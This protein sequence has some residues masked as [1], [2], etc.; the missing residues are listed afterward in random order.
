MTH[1]RSRRLIAAIG[2]LAL[3]LSG[4]AAVAVEVPSAGAATTAGGFVG[5]TPKRLL[6]TRPDGS[7]VTQRTGCIAATDGGGAGRALTVTGTVNSQD[8]TVP[9]SASAVALNVTVVAPSAAGFLTVYPTGAAKPTASSVNYTAGQVVPNGVFVKV[10]AGGQINL[11]ANAGCPQ[12]IVDVV[13]YFEGTTPTLPGGFNGVTPK[14]LLDTRPD[15]TGVVQATGCVAA[16]DGGG[17]GRALK[18]TG[19]VNSQDT[20]VPDGAAAVALNVTV[21]NPSVAGFVTVYP[22]GAAKPNASSVNYTAGQVVPNNVQ[23]AV[24][25]GGQ[26]NLFA[27]GGCPQVIVDVVGYTTGGAPVDE[28]GFIGV[29]P[30]RLLDTRPDGSAVTQR[31]GCVAATDGFGT[32]RALKVTGTVNS[33]S[34]TVPDNASAVALNIT[35]VTPG[36]AGFLTAYP[37]GATK[38]NAS[39]LNFTAGQVVPNGTVVKVGTGGQI[40]LFANAGCPQVIVDVVGYYVGATAPTGAPTN[41]DS[42]GS[43]IFGQLGDPTIPGV[44]QVPQRVGTA[45]DWTAV[46]TN[47]SINVE[48][49]SACGIRTGQLFCWGANDYGQ[50]GIGSTESSDVPVRVGTAT[51]WQWVSVGGASA[52][53]VRGLAPNGTL[54]CWGD[55]SY[56]QVGDGTGTQQESPVQITDVI[57]DALGSIAS[58]PLGWA[59]V[60]VAEDHACAVRSTGAQYYCWGDNSYGQ[61]GDGTFDAQYQPRIIGG[62]ASWVQPSAGT[63][64]SC[65]RRGPNGVNGATAL[66]CGGDNT[67]GQLGDDTGVTPDVPAMQR[68]DGTTV[69]WHT[70][71]SGDTHVCAI[72]DS[73]AASPIAGGL[74]CW[75][76][77]DYG[78]VGDGTFNSALAPVR[79]GALS[80]WSA[81]DAGFAHSCGVRVGSL[82]CWGAGADYRT[83]LASI[84]DVTA[85]VQVGVDT[86]WA[87]V[88]AGY[89]SSCG[90]RTSGTL[91]C[92]G[93]N[94]QGQLGIPAY[95][96]TP[97]AT[98]VLTGV[99]QVSTGFGASCAVRT[100][101]T[102]WCWGSNAT[103]LLSDGTFLDS[104]VP[105]QV[106]IATNWASVTVGGQLDD[107][108]TPAVYAC[109]VKTAGT[110]WCWGDNTF[111]QLGLG[112]A[113]PTDT[114]TQ[115]GSLTTWSS[116]SAG[117]A[118]TCGVAAGGV[119]CWGAGGSGQIGNNDVLNKVSP[120]AISGGGTWTSVSVG[121]QQVCGI[122]SDRTLW[123]WGGNN[124]GQLGIGSTVSQKVPTQ[125]GTATDWTQVSAGG[126]ASCGIRTGGLLLCWGGN[127]DGQVGDGTT[128]QRTSPV[129]VGV[130]T[131][132]KQVATTGYANFPED[133][134]SCA[135]ASSGTLGSLWCW[136]GNGVGQLGNGTTVRALAPTQVGTGIGWGSVVVAD[137][138]TL[139]LRAS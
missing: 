58:R 68:V 38:P 125:V 21:V 107:F 48:Q 64:S 26:I 123:C 67:Y 50:L 41:L 59:S 128:T 104:Q 131:V 120:T 91:W 122:R 33:Q 90:I 9:V 129:P 100:D 138:Q 30:K 139:A 72:R 78:Q 8:T 53:G 19:T 43:N 135:V 108:G 111:G 61:L 75:G 109:A 103:G 79:I 74:W 11:F 52:C 36:A 92:W 24:G 40:N 110:A 95:R 101:A 34:T 18:V 1:H 32:G 25:T 136:G 71:T 112:S 137:T 87:K 7:G 84:D 56:G 70:V 102:L 76:G 10:G 126:V 124:L 117:A 98:P 89:R 77:N 132:W 3:T 127:L 39:T 31:T 13:G 27:S 5:L 81:V 134:H 80:T 73:S 63:Y 15:G 28:G 97:G 46:S 115:V 116:I 118:T 105:V 35:V 93:A 14:R 55:N 16:S 130:G 37:T 69:N 22:T 2:G 45:S 133:A 29:T 66:F 49:S 114:P 54:W 60:D 65:S 23:V 51:D 82:L 42:W 62:A 85:P 17:A 113:S 99:A 4:L 47:G 88:S 96:S 86:D 106:G 44:A 94:N 119:L 57:T 20:T 121:D 83:G 12:V 6:D